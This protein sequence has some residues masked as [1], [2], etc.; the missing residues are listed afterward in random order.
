MTYRKDVDY[1]SGCCLA[2]PM[3]LWRELG[4]FDVR[5]VP[6]YYEDTDLA[7]MV[8]SRGKRVVYEPASVIV[9]LEGGTHGTDI[10]SGLKAFQVRNRELFRQ[11]WAKELDAFHPLPG[12]DVFRARERSQ[13]KA[14][15]VVADRGIPEFD[16]DAGSQCVMAYLKGF[17]SVG[18]Q[19]KYIPRSFDRVEP[20]ASELE[21][22]GIEVLAGPDFRWGWQEWFR[23]HGKEISLVWCGRPE[24]ANWLFRALDTWSSAPRAFFVHDLHYIRWQR[25]ASLTG[26]PK[27]ARLARD[28]R[29]LEKRLMSSAELNLMITSLE[30]E[31]ARK[32]LGLPAG[33]LM[34]VPGYAQEP[35]WDQGATSR[36][37][38][39]L[40]F[41]GNFIHGPNVDG[42]QWF[43]DECWPSI[44]K[45]E[46]EAELLLVGMHMPEGLQA[47]AGSTPGVRY[48]GWQSQQ[49]LDALYR[50][51]RVAILPLRYGA[52]LKGKA[53]EAL[54]RG[55]PLVGTS[56][57]WEGIEGFR[58]LYPS[59][60]SVQQ[61]TTAVLETFGHPTDRDALL[62]GLELI[63]SH[64]SPRAVAATA[65]RLL[66]LRR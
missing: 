58:D 4:G 42:V 55:V 15:V 37:G 7:F 44:R 25:E 39:Q 1:V 41:V 14:L 53:I 13:T 23:L 51:V 64:Y 63:E 50:T 49:Q 2:I 22:L 48:L 33:R 18:A 60:D 36:T 21:H 35:D 9:H 5:F 57:A 56:I 38:T 65:R 11:K 12:D 40:L 59:S 32:D 62:R 47:L 28:S 46:P 20:Y 10:A 34:V 31:T 19:V 8:R 54:A 30:A 3:E 45:A 52:G 16:K 27:V 66:E 26:S 24:A 6:A 61:F 29:A 17:L 43:L